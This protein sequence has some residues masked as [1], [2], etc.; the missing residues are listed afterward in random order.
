MGSHAA[1]ERYAREVLRMR[2]YRPHS[3]AEI[4]EGRQ[5]GPEQGCDAGYAIGLQIGRVYRGL[6]GF[7]YKK[8]AS[9]KKFEKKH[10][11]KALKRVH[12]MLDLDIGK[13]LKLRLLV[14]KEIIESA[15]KRETSLGA[16]FMIKGLDE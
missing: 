5:E 4:P 9:Y 10:L 16:H 11:Q 6:R 7:V 12:E 1:G 3:K 13:L 15:L 8:F 2:T 14:S